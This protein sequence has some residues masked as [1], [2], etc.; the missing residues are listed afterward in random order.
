MAIS[1]S[2]RAGYALVMA[3]MLAAGLSTGTRLYY[4]IFC[5]LFGMLLLGAASALWTLYT[6][7]FDIRG[8][9]TRVRRGERMTAVF[10]VRHA[11]LL[12]VSAA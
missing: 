5:A 10:T 7:R 3:A 6:L 1:N 4:L 9:R 8:V 12:P 2:R 11:C